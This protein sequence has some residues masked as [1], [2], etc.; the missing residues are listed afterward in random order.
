MLRHVLTKRLK[1]EHGEN[2]LKVAGGKQPFPAWDQV[3]D[4]GR[5]TAADHGGQ[6]TGDRR[7]PSARMWEEGPAH[8]E[9][10]M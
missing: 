3:G 8:C 10:Y 7:R 4:N 6:A 1:T 2:V 9:F 5:L